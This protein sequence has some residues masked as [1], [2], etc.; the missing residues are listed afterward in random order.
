MARGAKLRVRL[1]LEHIPVLEGAAALAEAGFG[2]GASGRNWSSYDG[3][4]TLPAGLPDWRRGLLCDPQTSG[5]L[6][7]AVAPEGAEALLAHIKT[8]GFAQAAVIGTME[9]G[10]PAVEIA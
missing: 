9:P 4:V 5:G 6:L 2:T 7:I 1:N 3:E 10:T 8:A